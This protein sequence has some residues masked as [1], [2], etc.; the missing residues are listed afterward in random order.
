[1]SLSSHVQSSIAPSFTDDDD[2]DDDDDAGLQ[3]A[4][5]SLGLQEA[6]K[7][8]RRAHSSHAGTE[9]VVGRRAAGRDDTL[10]V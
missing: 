7:A 10:S 9:A 4:L 6:P 8:K 2:D 5:S 1:M 3:E